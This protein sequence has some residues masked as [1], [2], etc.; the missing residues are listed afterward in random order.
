MHT[1]IENY[2]HVTVYASNV[3]LPT[4]SSCS[5]QALDDP[6]SRAALAMVAGRTSDRET[7]SNSNA[8]NSNN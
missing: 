1:Y 2:T 5:P 3:I 4:H 7:N 6:Q 8:T